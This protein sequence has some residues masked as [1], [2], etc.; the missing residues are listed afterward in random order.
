MGGASQADLWA[1]LIFSIIVA[2]RS[3][4]VGPNWM[5]AGQGW[6]KTTG[7]CRHLWST[8]D[9][10]EES[11]SW[12]HPQGNLVRVRRAPVSDTVE[13]AERILHGGTGQ[14][15]CAPRRYR[16]AWNSTAVSTAKSRLSKPQQ[17]CPHNLDM[18]PLISLSHHHHHRHHH[19]GMQF[20]W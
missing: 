11:P 4:W 9:Q 8:L 16:E 7:Q 6:A 20:H 10:P 1:K 17:W 15:A 14:L 5:Q 13:Q 2:N 12:R 3:G 18:S 19:L